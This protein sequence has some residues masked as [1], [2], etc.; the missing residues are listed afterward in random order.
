MVA[1]IAEDQ[2]GFLGSN[3]FWPLTKQRFDGLKLIHSGDAVPNFFAVWTMLILILFNLDRFSPQPVINPVTYF[4]L[5]WLPALV[6]LGYYIYNRYRA[7][8]TRR[9]PLV[10]LQQADLVSETQEV[11]DA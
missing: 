7:D 4:G 11:A 3:L 1:H 2:L 6:L 8:M 10:A 9:Q 5:A